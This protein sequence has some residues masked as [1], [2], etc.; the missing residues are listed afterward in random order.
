MDSF[1]KTPISLCLA[2]LPST[3][4]IKCDTHPSL[5]SCRPLGSSRS[6]DRAV[7]PALGRGLEKQVAHYAVN[8]YSCCF[9]FDRLARGPPTCGPSCYHYLSHMLWNDR[10]QMLV[11]TCKCSGQPRPNG[12]HPVLWETLGRSSESARPPRTERFSGVHVQAYQG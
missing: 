10:V 1:W 5:D 6:I 2:G 8:Y 4:L 3:K 7:Q 11:R 9:L 12:G